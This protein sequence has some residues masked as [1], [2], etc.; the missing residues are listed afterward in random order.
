MEKKY[1]KISQ[2]IQVFPGRRAFVEDEDLLEEAIDSC[3]F[4]FN[5][6]ECVVCQDELKEG[7]FAIETVLFKPR[8]NMKCERIVSDIPRLICEEC[9]IDYLEREGGTPEDTEQRSLL[10]LWREENFPQ[11]S[12]FGQ[13][14]TPRKNNVRRTSGDQEMRRRLSGDQEFAKAFKNPV[15]DGFMVVT[16]LVKTSA[17]DVGG[18]MVGD[19]YHS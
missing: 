7:D 6:F 5:F 9:S 17:A 15:D 19:V 13:V 11:E 18:L 14:L 3:N 1:K 8:V 2:K 10:E 12:N 16:Q 4:K